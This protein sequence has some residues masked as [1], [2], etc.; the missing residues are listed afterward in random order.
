MLLLPVHCR[1]HFQLELGVLLQLLIQKFL[2]PVAGLLLH[3]DCI[4]AHL[5]IVLPLLIAHLNLSSLG[6]LLLL[7]LIQSWCCSLCGHFN[8]GEFPF[9]S[10]DF[11][12]FDHRR[13]WWNQQSSW[14]FI[15]L[16]RFFLL[17]YLLC[18]LLVLIFVLI[19]FSRLLLFDDLDIDIGLSFVS[20]TSVWFFLLLLQIFAAAA[21]VF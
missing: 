16:H 14:S 3:L 19:F 9:G 21:I 20:C 18:N 4:S 5:D 12:N 2:V 17:H 6:E 11:S 1:V 7:P 10:F 8:I 13:W 15:Y